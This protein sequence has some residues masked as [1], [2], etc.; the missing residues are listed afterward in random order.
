MKQLLAFLALPPCITEFERAYLTRMNAF[1]MRFLIFNVPVFVVIAALN[2]TNPMLALALTSL[3]AAGPVLAERVLD[4]PRSVSRVFAVA[5][6]G[7]G[8]LLVHFGQGPMQIEMHF[9]FFVIIALLTVFGNPSA[10]LLAAA[11]TA[12][13]HLVIWWLF[14]RSVF[15]Y[16]ASA[17]VVAV[18]ATFVA[19]ESV[20][21][22]FVARS[23]F[24]NVIGLE[25]IVA[26]RT[27]ELGARGADMRLMLD[28]V[29]QGFLRV[30]LDGTMGDERSAILEEWLGPAEPGETAHAYF[31]RTDASAGVW[32]RVGLDLIADDVLPI[33]VAISQ[34]PTRMSAGPVALSLTYAPIKDGERVSSLLVIVS[35]ITDELARAEAEAEGAEMVG[36][37]E[38]IMKDGPGFSEFMSEAQGLVR[39]ISSGTPSLREARRHLHTLKGNSLLAGMSRFARVCHDL[40]SRMD[41]TGDLPTAGERAAFEERWRTSAARIDSLLVHRAPHIEL[42][43]AEHAALSAAVASARPRLEV[44]QMIDDLKLEPTARRLERVAQDARAVATRLG[45]DVSVEIEAG[46][47]RLSPLKWT[48]LWSSVVHLVRN[49]LDHGIEPPEERLAAGKPASGRLTLSTRVDGGDF[50]IGFADDGRGIDWG[51]VKALAEEHGLPHATQ[52]DLDQVLLTD[53]VSTKES[54]SEYSGRGVGM[55]AVLA[56]THDL[57]GVIRVRSSEAGRGTSVELRFP[58]SLLREPCRSG[59]ERTMS[60][61]IYAVVSS[62]PVLPIASHAGSPGRAL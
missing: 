16:S 56:A 14:P 44:L 61:R 6:I 42:T 59:V 46:D 36:V 1:A 2:R 45:R 30:R 12:A 54:V 8:G 29:G 55:S 34:M 20:A 11:T 57:G 15:N 33:E 48:P 52:S 25:R 32:F 22:C 19:I 38:R 28:S 4:N 21:C 27:T 50:V 43:E 3:V 31:G 10:I 49:A 58:R 39:M 26:Q 23:F 18:H 60:G 41:E 53:G 9:Y 37:F 17:W 24:D 5:G 35:D 47:I 51:R 13:H 7:M 62:R 40:E